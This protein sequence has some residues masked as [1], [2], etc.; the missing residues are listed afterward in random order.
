MVMPGAGKVT[1]A[2]RVPPGLISQTAPGAQPARVAG[3]SLRKVSSGFAKVRVKPV[4]VPGMTLAVLRNADSVSRSFTS[5]LTGPLPASKSTLPGVNVAP[6]TLTSK[7]SSATPVGGVSW[8]VTDTAEAPGGG[9]IIDI[10][11]LPQPIRIRVTNRYRRDTA[12]RAFFMDHSS[13]Q[14]WAWADWRIG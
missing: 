11:P 3:V 2:V 9:V 1:V 7:E 6:V 10:E 14:D 8:M 13:H 12:R 4:Y 5:M